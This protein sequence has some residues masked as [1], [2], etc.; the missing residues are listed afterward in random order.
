[1]LKYVIILVGCGATGSNIA[2][3]L[4]QLAISQKNIKEI[5]LVDGDLV[6]EK[7]FRNQKFTSK[8]IGK[9]KSHVLA[10][11]YSK[12]GINVSYVDRYINNADDLINIIKHKADECTRV[13]LVGSVD[14]NEARR[15]MNST[16]Y[17]EDIPELIYIDTGN[18]DKDRVG[19]T[20]AGAKM[21]NKV[22]TPPVAEYYPQILEDEVKE[23]TVEDY[24]CSHIEEHPQ[25]FATNVLSA[26]TTFLMI[27]NIVSLGKVGCKFARFNA[28]QIKIR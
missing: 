2:A 10:N 1:M 13:L 24:R 4:S 11:R 26:T 8:D 9:Y 28:D 14:N 18:G 6:E 3:F 21:D 27:N 17:S 5:I 20:V 12:L 25:N 16:F 22:I 23:E 15:Y 19:Q 7:N